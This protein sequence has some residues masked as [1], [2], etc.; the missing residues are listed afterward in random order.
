MQE[1]RFSVQLFWLFAA[2]LIFAG[3]ENSIEPLAEDADSFVFMNGFLDSASD[4][5]FVRLSGLRPTILSDLRDI[6]D[7]DVMTVDKSSGSKVF[8]RDS[9]IVLDDGSEGH[10][11]VG[12]LSPEEGHEY[13]FVVRRPGL[14]AATAT[15][16]VPGEP[17]LQVSD[18]SREVDLLTQ[19][20]SLLNLFSL[21][22]KLTMRYDIAI[23][24]TGEIRTFRI[25]YS[26]DGRVKE[27]GLLY[28]VLLARDMQIISFSLGREPLSDT[29]GLRRI[30]VEVVVNSAEW[31]HQDKPV[32]MS[33]AQG[34]F[35]SV[36][37]FNIGWRLDPIDVNNIG[38][39]DEQDLWIVE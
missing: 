38:F 31:S 19:R 9:L 22:F 32:N 7:A 18:P 36:G 3:C 15:T 6:S 26:G 10:L 21:P 4:T 2:T 30:S 20:I 33:L 17:E 25:D 23:P 24:E 35:G 16:T 8:W 1:T 27:T 39:A 14:S 5:Q 11:F 37:R 28:T 34:F 13:E 12:L 29:L